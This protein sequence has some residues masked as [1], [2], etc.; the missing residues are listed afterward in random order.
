MIILFGLLLAQIVSGDDQSVKGILNGDVLLPCNCSGI[1][2]SKAWLWQM[3]DQ[4]TKVLKYE[5]GKAKFTDH[6]YSDRVQTFFSENHQNCS[7]LLINITAKDQGKYSCRFHTQKYQKPSVHLNISVHYTVK[8][9]EPAVNLRDDSKVFQ[10]DAVGA[11]GEAQIQWS[12]DGHVLQNSAACNISSDKTHNVS[13]GLYHFSSR[14]IIKFHGTTPKCDVKAEGLS[15]EI[16]I[17][18]NTQ[19]SALTETSQPCSEPKPSLRHQFFK[20]IPM[21]LVVGL[22]LVLWRRSKFSRRLPK[23]D[24]DCQL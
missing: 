17:T 2:L 15:T 11:Y 4:Q 1:N 19:T 24:E 18:N 21:M 22:F 9:T 5:N 14:L 10:C 23:V 20:I 12:M 6:R 16:Y 3:E 13:S 7:I 8:Q